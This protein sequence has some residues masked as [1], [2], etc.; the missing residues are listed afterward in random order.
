MQDNT[1]VHLLC[2][3]LTSLLN[4]YEQHR[5]NTDA[6]DVISALAWMLCEVAARNK[7]PRDVFLS[8]LTTTYDTT[9]M[10]MHEQR[11]D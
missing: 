10:C 7:V 3:N 5:P 4:A 6:N 8:H 2:A 11:D 1:E 9:I